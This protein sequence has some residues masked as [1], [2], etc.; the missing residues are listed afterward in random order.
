MEKLDLR[1]FC[2]VV[3]SYSVNSPEHRGLYRS[4]FLGYVFDFKEQEDEEA[5]FQGFQKQSLSMMDELDAFT[6]QLG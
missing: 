5:G 2:D 1:D 3:Y 4:S 6:N